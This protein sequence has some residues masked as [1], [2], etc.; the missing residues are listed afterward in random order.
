MPAAYYCDWLKVAAEEALHFRLLTDHL[1]TLGVRYGDLPAHDGLW[2][3]AERTS[4]DVLARM[5]LVPRTLEARGLDASPA[6]RDKLASVGDHAG[7]AIID[8]ILRDEIGHVA[9]GNRWF[10]HLCRERALEPVAAYVALTA[11]YDAPRLRG[12]FNLA[13]RRAAGFLPE[14]IVALSAS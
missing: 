1:A 12:P 9:C 11:R 8:V 4:A 10:H 3:M 6:V 13:A 7:A 2:Q 14:E 5:A